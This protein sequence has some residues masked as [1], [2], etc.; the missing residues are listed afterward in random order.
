MIKQLINF[1][2]ILN[3]NQ[4][5]KFY[6]YLFS[7]VLIGIIEITGLVTIIPLVNIFLEKDIPDYLYFLNDYIENFNDLSIVNFLIFYIAFIVIFYFLK[8]IIISI[9]YYYQIKFSFNI[10]KI[11]M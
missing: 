10:Q 4:R 6:W 9:S 8:F 5:S 1:I 3:S 2:S 11:F 7:V